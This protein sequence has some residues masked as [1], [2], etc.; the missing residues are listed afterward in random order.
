MQCTRNQP[1]PLIYRPL[2]QP[3]DTIAV[4]GSYK[5]NQRLVLSQT[6]EVRV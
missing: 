1:Y 4:H 3:S 5:N 2:L 6:M